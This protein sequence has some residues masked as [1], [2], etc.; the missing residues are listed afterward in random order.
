MRVHIEF[1]FKMYFNLQPHV[2]CS[3]EIKYHCFTGCLYAFSYYLCNINHRFH[4]CSF[5]FYIGFLLHIGSKNGRNIE[6]G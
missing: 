2:L 3:A 1:A 5:V 6:D 4:T